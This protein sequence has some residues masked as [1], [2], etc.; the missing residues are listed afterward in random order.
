MTHCACFFH[1]PPRQVSS[2]VSNL[3]L[4][5]ELYTIINHDWAFH[6]LPLLATSVTATHFAS[7]SLP[8]GLPRRS[9]FLLQCPLPLRLSL[10]PNR[11]FHGFTATKPSTAH[12]WTAADWFLSIKVIPSCLS[13]HRSGLYDFLKPLVNPFRDCQHSATLCFCAFAL[14]H[15]SALILHYFGPSLLWFLISDFSFLIT[16]RLCSLAAIISRCVW[17]I[18]LRLPAVVSVL[19]LCFRP[20]QVSFFFIAA[21]FPRLGTPLSD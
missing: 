17:L 11:H 7:D 15:F 3:R 13:P 18:C 19:Q 6:F 21:F 16:H 1:I 5:P 10:L 4:L 2:V 14:P 9:Q 20:K 12:Y 8:F